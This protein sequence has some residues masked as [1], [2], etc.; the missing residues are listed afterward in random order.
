MSPVKAQS[1]KGALHYNSQLRNMSDMQFMRHLGWLDTGSSSGK[2]QSNG[3]N[4]ADS[5]SSRKVSYAAQ[6]LSARPNYSSEYNQ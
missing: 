4:S 3:Q 6:P 2:N 5:S 1:I